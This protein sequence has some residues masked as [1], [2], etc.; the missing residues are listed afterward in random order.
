[1]RFTLKKFCTDVKLE[2]KKSKVKVRKPRDESVETLEIG[3]FHDIYQFI[4]K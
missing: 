3:N 2:T 1:M 4:F